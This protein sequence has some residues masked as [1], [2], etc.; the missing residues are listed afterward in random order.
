VAGFFFAVDNRAKAIHMKTL[1][2]FLV[3]GLAIFASA[4]Q[5]VKTYTSPNGLFRLQYSD[6]L[7]NCASQQTPTGPTESSASEG[8]Q[9]GVSTT[10]DSCISQG[11]ICDGPGSEGSTLA[12][13][14]YPKERFKDK[15]HFVA[16]SF[17]VSEIQPAKTEKEC[18]K[19]SPGWFVINSKAGTTTIGQVSFKTF[20]IGDNWTGGGQSGPAYRAFHDA[21]CYEL[22]VQTVLSRAEYDPGTVEEFTKKD[23]SEVEGRLRQAL[24][25]FAFLK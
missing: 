17:Y 20:E 6:V 7:I 22:G 3:C 23:F 16:A 1:I 25:S 18:L 12:C 10:S 2:T 15:P 19:G 14:A 8:D 11:E 9:P 4:Q 21:K 13:F 5:S 24:T